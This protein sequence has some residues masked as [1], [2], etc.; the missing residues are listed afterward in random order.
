M[1]LSIAATGSNVLVVQ[2]VI[3]AV[4]TIVLAA[5]TSL[6]LSLFRPRVTSLRLFAW[7]AVLYAGLSMP[8][9]AWLLHPIAIPFLP[10]STRTKSPFTNRTAVA[11]VETS[12]SQPFANTEVAVRTAA[13][14]PGVK[15]ASSHNHPPDGS[16][17]STWLSGVHWLHWTELI[18]A[19]Y[20]VITVFLL[21]RLIA[22]LKFSHRL[23]RS[24][25]PI[26][27]SRILPRLSS[28]SVWPIMPRVRE[29]SLV[30]VPV[31]IGVINSTIL[32]PLN[33]QEWDIAKLN[34]VIT[35]EM[36]HAMRRDTLSL[37]VSLLHRAIFWFSPFAWWL[38]RH[39]AEL[40]E[41]ASDEAALAA[42][43]ERTCYANTLLGFFQTVK[44]SPGRVQWQGVS[45]ATTDRAERRLEK[46]LAW[47]GDKAMRVK[48]PAMAVAIAITV[49]A[50]YMTAAAAPVV[51][52]QS[53]HGAG[54]MQGQASPPSDDA[55]TEAQAPASIP[56]DPVMPP[57]PVDS[58]VSHSG[59]PPT[60]P[61][62]PVPPP[63]Q[64]APT[65]PV[66][67]VASEDEDSAM[68]HQ[69]GFSYT[70]DF[71]DEQRFAIVSGKSDR[72]MTWGTSEDAGHVERLK[73]RI[74]GDFIW[75]QR[76]EKSYIIRDQATVDRARQLWEP[77]Q[78]LGEK[79][80]ELGK[81]QEA[82]GKQQEELSERMQ[83]LRVKVPDM[84]TELDKLKA[85][86]Q[87]L[88]P[89]ANIA[90]IGDVQAQIGVLQ[91]RIGELQATVG[92][93]QGK[94][95]AEMGALGAQQGRLGEQQR[96][97]SRQQA[98][99]GRKAGRAM[100]ELLDDAIK[101]G[102]AQPEPEKPGSASL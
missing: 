79:Q 11:S 82:L 87:Q 44:D 83:K 45:M 74:P 2:L 21:F 92:S 48:R 64:A 100:K 77:Q 46:I 42:G 88:G 8:L 35:H 99:I 14:A 65:P 3:A 54:G 12:S 72:F 95:G 25:N 53:G 38:N 71:D 75:F 57:A 94:F 51:H 15:I 89:E 73:Q 62:G 10:S 58:G 102:L 16:R 76:D 97:L 36:S 90:Q 34:A 19:G 32:L 24:S 18:S 1:P 47:R 29:T 6:L 98:E 101:K 30:S 27:E 55:P 39:L 7:T 20:L 22:G 26:Q 66:S 80:A 40:A 86:L 13:I 78:E 52:D 96:E 28:R 17:A 63:T 49:A 84:T 85:Q 56:T 91:S 69:H 61:N 4:R 93:E 81:Q 33:W 70:Y 37:H 5:A 31:T 9:L 60:Q 41:E 23:V 50:I 68:S 43:T 59:P 67:P